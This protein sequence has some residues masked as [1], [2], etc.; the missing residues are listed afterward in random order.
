MIG[1][2]MTESQLAFVLGL[3]LGGSNF[4][5][6]Y[7]HNNSFPSA[8]PNPRTT[9]LLHYYIIFSAKSKYIFLNF[10]AVGCPP[11]IRGKD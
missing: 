6:S 8:Q 5:N 4:L 3:S 1:E 2:Y 11:T 10:A 9:I 7:F